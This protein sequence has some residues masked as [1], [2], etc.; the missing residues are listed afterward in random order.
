M[1]IISLAILGF[2]LY[3]SAHGQ[4][5]KDTSF[6]YFPFDSDQL[7]SD[8]RQ[9]LQEFLEIFQ[10][11]PGKLTIYG[12]CDFKGSH[13]YN[14]RLSNKR[15][16][17]VRQWLEENGVAAEYITMVKGWGKRNPLNNNSSEDERSLNRRVE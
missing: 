6:I 2:F 8:A 14:D 10:N 7:T 5:Q 17:V 15:T 4:N 11:Q 16:S 9:Q 12:H 13:E 3:S 1:K